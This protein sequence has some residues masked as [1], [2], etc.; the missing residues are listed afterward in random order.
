MTGKI[1]K[2]N[3]Q[4]KKG[5]ISS[6]IFLILGI[7]LVTNSNQIVTI[8]FQAIGAII[9]VIGLYYVFRYISL[10]KQF[11]TED[12]NALMTGILASAIGLLTILLASIL[13]VGLRYTIGFYLILNGI[14]K[15][16]F[17]IQMPDRSSK[18]FISKLLEGIL[19]L[20]L[21]LYT[22]FVANAALIIVG[23]FLIISSIYDLIQFSQQKR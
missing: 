2:P 5:L 21:G 23:I 22:L 11:K 13:E 9:I 19:L 4:N 10:K 3:D 18:L 16:G 15:I 8:A 17:A 7:V 20:L 1:I 6:I 12:T 14:S